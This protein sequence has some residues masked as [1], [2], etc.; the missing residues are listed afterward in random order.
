[1]AGCGGAAQSPRETNG[2]FRVRKTLFSK[3]DQRYEV[4]GAEREKKVLA[5]AGEE[6]IVKHM[7]IC[8]LFFQLA[9]CFFGLFTAPCPS[10]RL[11]VWH[12]CLLYVAGSPTLPSSLHRTKSNCSLTAIPPQRPTPNAVGARQALK[13]LIGG[14]K[15]L[16]YRGYDSAGV[17]LVVEGAGGGSALRV[18]KKVGK[19]VNVERA[20]GEAGVQ[21]T[22]G[23]AHTRWAT[24]G[25]PND[26]NSHPHCDTAGTVAVVH[27]GII[28]NYATL[29]KALQGEGCVISRVFFSRAREE[30]A[31]GLPPPSPPTPTTLLALR[32]HPPPAPPAAACL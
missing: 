16:E 5:C 3:R 19:V 1:M 29:K 21:S 13:L 2:C 8:L 20:A 11:H 10:E 15:R 26:V 23:I 31:V 18:V 7:T 24:H 32:S 22:L 30:C 14:L 17:G 4:W 6:K 28:E 12:H 25:P 9:F 27:N